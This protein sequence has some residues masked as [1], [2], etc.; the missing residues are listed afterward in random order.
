MGNK[1]VSQLV[2]L[3]A[4]AVSI[5]DLFLIID[6]SARES[7]KIAVQN[8][9]TYL[10]ASGSLLAV[11][12]TFADTASYVLGSDVHGAVSSASYAQNAT[13]A[14]S[15]S[16]A[17][18]SINSV[19]ASNAITAAFAQF[20]IVPSELVTGST[21]PI[22]ASWANIAIITQTS[23]Y[24]QYTGISNGTAS[25]AISA[26]DA[27]FAVTASYVVGGNTVD[28]AAFAFVAQSVLDSVIECDSA[29]FLN[30]SG[31]Y[32]GTASY[33]LIAGGIEHRLENFGMFPAL[34]QTSTV[35][36]IDNLMI[37]SSM[38]TD[39]PTMIEAVGTAVMTWT[40][41]I[42]NSADLTLLLVDRLTGFSGSFDKL[43]VFY[44][45]TP[46]VN[47]WNTQ[48]TGSYSFPFSFCGQS[49]LNGNYYI[50]VTSS[51][52][53]LTI[54]PDR[55]VRFTVSSYASDVTASADEAI[56]FYYEPTVNEVT[57]SSFA[58]GPF[59]DSLDG[60]LITGSNNIKTIDMSSASIST[61]RYTWKLF[62]CTDF[63]CSQNASL[64]ELNY[65]FPNTMSYLYCSECNIGSIVDLDNT[66][67]LVFDCST[68]NLSVL[69]ALP[70]TVTYL[71][72]SYNPIVSFNN[73][74]PANTQQFVATNIV[75]ATSLSGFNDALLTA[76]LDSSTF[77]SL[78]TLPVSIRRL[79]VSSN[80]SLTSLPDLSP[81][82]MSW[83]DASICDLNTIPSMSVSMSWI[84]LSSNPPLV[85]SQFVSCT[86]DLVNSAQLSGTFT[87]LGYGAAFATAFYGNL[88]TLRDT[89]DWSI[90]VDGFP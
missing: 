3:T 26:E 36:S 29:S 55:T 5:D 78:P 24:L 8:L 40:S 47:L 69:P 70:S 30:F 57:F 15:A 33:A 37:S 20:A 71:N 35:A 9:F 32:N 7:K 68:N 41:S 51:N 12:A 52:D 87:A 23:S 86:N 58:G 85:P 82:S 65:G 80:T 53:R 21:Y 62:N 16:F 61:L 64:N 31:E 59:Y 49:S 1:R 18:N 4:D 74:L 38:G 77:S 56:D 45:V 89:Y 34:T 6:T 60:I 42:H 76:S 48:A 50:A 73:A 14:F 83:L 79:T 75:G 72:C 28:T 22:T 17:Q 84:D 67:L 54:H 46:I 13:T 63:S 90:S 43:Q 25:F 39:E 19:S 81:T 88:L 2:E 27:E 10:N 66:N 11:H 44:D